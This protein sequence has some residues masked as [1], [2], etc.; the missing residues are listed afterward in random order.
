MYQRQIYPTIHYAQNGGCC[1]RRTR[2]NA[3]FKVHR[4]HMRHHCDV[5]GTKNHVN[6]RL[7]RRSSQVGRRHMRTRLNCNGNVLR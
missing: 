3:L 2:F 7:Q 1:G 6:R 4:V 5:P